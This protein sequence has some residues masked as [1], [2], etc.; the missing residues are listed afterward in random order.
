MNLN[1][2]NEITTLAID[3]SCDETSCSVVRGTTVL[4]NVMP[5]QQEYHAKY[6]GVVPNLARLAHQERIDNVVLEALKRAFPKSKYLYKSI[7]GYMEE[8]D[9]ISVTIGPGL[10]IALEIGIRKAKELASNFAKPLILINHMEGHMFSAFCEKKNLKKQNLTHL[11]TSLKKKKMILGFLI[12][13]NH[14]E[15]VKVNAIGEYEKIGETLDDSCGEAY[16]KC[17][18]ILG[19][20]YPA[21]PLISNFAKI[22]R[23]KIKLD[24]VKD[25]K[26]TLLI[27]KNK[28][29]GVTYQLPIPMLQSG[30]LNMSYSGLKT[31][32]KELVDSLIS[33]SITT[34]DQIEGNTKGLSK[35]EIYDLCVIFE[36]AALKQLEIKLEKAI[37]KYSPSLLLLGGGVVA[38]ARLRS[39]FRSICKKYKV[40]ILF[41]TQKKFTGDNAAMIGLVANLRA[42]YVQSLGSSLNHNEKVDFTKS[43]LS[44][45]KLLEQQ[46]ILINNFDRIDR[47]PSL[48]IGEKI[49]LIHQ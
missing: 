44:K 15:M 18:R 38:S 25:N 17:G 23:K 36:A 16:D 33:G 11:Q 8:V 26:R 35:E 21:G 5:S 31:A 22:H 43:G 32:F 47:D 34:K 49:T 28:S 40:E 24:I 20:G 37:K 42:T 13:G 45:I 19:L 27:G 46:G 39:V 30:D 2:T 4:S 41:P 9:T 10:A 48:E 3:T 29:T 14:T 1:S 6:G 12:S 7:S